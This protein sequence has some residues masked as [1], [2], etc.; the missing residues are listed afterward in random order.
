MNTQVLEEMKSLVNILNE[1]SDAY[2]NGCEIMSDYLYDQ[3]FDRLKSLEEDFHYVLTDSPTRNVGYY[4]KVDKLDKVKHEF[5]ARSL[6]K[7]KS[8]DKVVE[9]FTLN[10]DEDYVDLMWKLDG[11]TIQLTYDEGKLKLA[12]T[13]GNGEVGQDI[14]HNAHAIHNI[15]L[16]IPYKE[17]LVVRGEAVMSYKDFETINEE[18]P[19]EL[20]YKNPRNLASA[21]ITMLDSSEVMNRNIYFIAF[22]LVDISIEINS[23]FDRLVFL[24]DQ[25]FTPVKVFKFAASE[26]PKY[27][28]DVYTPKVKDYE[29][30]VD[31][32]VAVYDDI[33]VSK[34]YKGT[35]HHPHPL[36]GYAYK[37][38]DEIA[39]TTLLDIEW[40]LSRTGLLNPVAVFEPVELEGTTVTRASLHNF[41]VMENLHIRKGDTIAVYKANK[42][43]PQVSHVVDDKGPYSINEFV[44]ITKDIETCPACGEKVYL[45]IP[46]SGIKSLYC[47]NPFCKGQKVFKFEHFCSRDCMNIEGLSESTLKMLIED[48]GIISEYT[49][50]YHLDEHKDE[51]VGRE[52]FGEKSYNNL[53]ESINNSRNTTLDRVIAAL[54]IS[55]VGNVQAKAIAEFI[56]Y[57]S[58]KFLDSQAIDYT[59][60]KG[61]GE[62]VNSSIRDYMKHPINRMQYENLIRELNL[63]EPEGASSSKLSGLNFVIT[64]KVTK[65]KN[66]KELKK[67][68]E[69]NGGKVLDSVT[70][71]TSFLINN[72]EN[73]ASSKNKNAIKLGVP[74]IDEDNFMKLLED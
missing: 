63:E 40:S 29:F 58:Q 36:R 52:R 10:N 67:F 2:Y 28:Q 23:F 25:G 4:P 73:S 43:I 5:T 38:N 22:E 3:Q 11:S 18:L 13:R 6:D 32:L 37:W 64:G 8:V 35:S 66:R 69:A 45:D 44:E 60:I 72:D 50:L 53:I 57:D 14:T 24:I 47:K 70:S 51:I 27:I 34:K 48:L 74:I 20:K 30:P 16:E 17:K 26:L 71:N 7:T 31:G 62:S 65:F 56:G 55:N 15:P 68:I 42:I 49:D 19:D 61:I 46:E 39:E 9:T 54:G 41:S 21:S 33:T 1:A 12:A 59:Q